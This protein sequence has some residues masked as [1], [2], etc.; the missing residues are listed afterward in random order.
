MFESL[1]IVAIITSCQS[2]HI[3]PK[4]DALLR[5]TVFCLGPER[6]KGRKLLNCAEEKEELD[7]PNPVQFLGKRKPSIIMLPKEHRLNQG[8]EL[9]EVKAKGKV[10]NSES[11]YLIVY[12]K[13]EKL[14]T[15]FGF[16]ASTKVSK[17]AV[18]RNR[19][20]R[21]LRESVRQ[22]LVR[23]KPGYD[24]VFIVKPLATKKST[25]EIMHESQNFLYNNSLI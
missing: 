18:I 14:P 1:V 20:I 11:F 21:A 5:N 7:C 25:P 17:S 2:E 3:N 4:R 9:D 24:C 22:N 12:K 23:L 16:V 6:E 13:N 8:K 15:R 19:I 10:K